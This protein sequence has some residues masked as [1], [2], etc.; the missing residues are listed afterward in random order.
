MYLINYGL[1]GF[2]EFQ[3]VVSFAL[4][5]NATVLNNT[6]INSIFP[7]VMPTG[8]AILLLSAS[9]ALTLVNV[10]SPSDTMEFAPDPVN[11]YTYGYLT[12]MQITP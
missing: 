8:S 1:I 7:T 3:G 5:Q 2:G 9:D 11:G 6:I 4:Q 12:I 10:T